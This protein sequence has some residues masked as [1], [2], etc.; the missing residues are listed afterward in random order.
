[1]V[2]VLFRSERT[3]SEDDLALARHLSRAAKGA[4]ERSELF[5][6]ERRERGRSQRLATAAAELTRNLAPE[7]VLDE[8]VAQARTLLGADAAT[9]RLI[10]GED[11]VVRAAAGAGG[12]G[13]VGTRSGS[14]AGL[15]GEVAQSRRPRSFESAAGDPGLARGDALLGAGMAAAAAVPLIGQGGGV[16]RGVLG[17]YSRE[18]RAWRADEV[19]ALSAL[20][21]LA[22]AA[23]ANAELY[24]DVA[25]EKER[26][27]AILANIAD[28]IVATDR[29]GRIV[30]WNETAA[31]ITGVPAAEAVGR[32]VPETLQRELAAEDGAP[33]GERQVSIM[34]GSNEIWLS[35]TEAVMHD[36]D[37][38]IAGRIFA[39][40]DISGERAV[41]ELKSDFVATVSHELRTPLTSIYGFAETLQRS[42]IVF[43][44]AERAT[45]L[46][47]IVSESE[48]LIHIVDDLL[49]VARLEAG[50]LD[51]A[52]G[53]TDVA[54]A[55][56]QAV[57][58]VDGPAAAI[59]VDVPDGLI[60]EADGVRLVEVLHQLMDNAVKFSPA[61]GTV[62]VTGRRT[63]DAVEVAV[64]DEGAGIA[65]GDRPRIFTKFFRG[66]EGRVAVEGT[67]IGLFLA[68][69]L[70]A[71]MHGRI[72]LEPIEGD[73]S[74]FV[75]E[76]PASNAAR[77]GTEERVG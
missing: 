14:G 55:V 37:G 6:G 11:L 42:D 8:V 63:P 22:G 20:A 66:S 60:A 68:R 31:D 49:N 29:D 19:Q 26:S 69:G 17:A 13:L 58:R 54:D 64:E 24:R 30:L 38:G 47:Y 44:E 1:M 39:F 3:F 65:P 56:G 23:L 76:L 12:A 46:A 57:A 43:D 18:P 27:E 48:R 73:G 33:V 52:L 59:V 41:E 77:A 71:A 62:T 75:F 21:A 50:T 61:G 36:A 53:P 35:L 15:S 40:R 7:R 67:G 70:V 72:W 51:L 5:E 45:F 25:E 28:G 32:R 2:V 34:R 10:E 74:R 4:L 9:V 16:V